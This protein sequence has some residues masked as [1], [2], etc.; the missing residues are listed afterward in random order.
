MTSLSHLADRLSVSVYKSFRRAA[1]DFC[2]MKKESQ[3][4]QRNKK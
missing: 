4:L 3:Q 1:A 2:E